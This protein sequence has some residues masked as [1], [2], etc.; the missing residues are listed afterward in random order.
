MLKDRSVM[1]AP[2]AFPTQVMA[3]NNLKSANTW[4]P[5]S[6]IKPYDAVL[7]LHLLHI[8]DTRG[9]EKEWG[10]RLLFV[11]ADKDS[12]LEPF[13]GKILIIRIMSI[14][15]ATQPSPTS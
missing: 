7:F 6:D 8:S 3:K 15:K 11:S 13:Q 9:K 1:K 12:F 10:I 4:F 2:G 5:L 14:T